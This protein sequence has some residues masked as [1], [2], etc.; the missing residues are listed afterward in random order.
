MRLGNIQG[1][2]P[3][4][5]RE[6]ELYASFRFLAENLRHPK[7]GFQLTPQAL[8]HLARIEPVFLIKEGRDLYAIAGLRTLMVLQSGLEPDTKIPVSIF[9]RIP[10]DH[11]NQLI[12]DSAFTDLVIK[13]AL[14]TIYGEAAHS[15]FALAQRFCES[16]VYLHLLPALKFKQ[17]FADFLGVNRSTLLHRSSKP[18]SKEVT[19]D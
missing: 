19:D 10:K 9:Q 13:P 5:R 1:A 15:L 11:R 12:L 4:I 7:G 6:A 16:A 14:Q 8:E 3:L 18:I 2:H 17:R